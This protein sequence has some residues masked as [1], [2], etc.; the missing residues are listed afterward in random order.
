MPSYRLAGILLLAL[1]LCSVGQ[2]TQDCSDE[3]FIVSVLDPAGA[4]VKDLVADNFRVALQ[5]QPAKLA[6]VAHRENPQAR[7]VVLLD[8]SGSMKGGQSPGKWRTALAAASDFLSSAP[9]QTQITFMTFDSKVERIFAATD[10]RGPIRGFLSEP[11]VQRGAMLKGKTAL[12]DVILKALNLLTPPHPGDAIYVITDGGDNSS[13]ERRKQL[14]RA[15]G[16][17]GVRLFGF[18]LNGSSHESEEELV[19]VPELDALVR[20]AGGLVTTTSPFKSGPGWVSS[21]D[22]S[23]DSIARERLFTRA[24]QAAIADFY[25]IGIQPGQADLKHLR[26][27]VVNPEGKLRKDVTISYPRE[28]APRICGS[29]K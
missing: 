25:V 21:Y 5:G 12:Y 28:S 18:L 2:A 14:S 4:P 13:A 26:V 19:G 9:P 7:V 22:F 8:V 23:Q 20:E 29:P 27:N 15:L 16:E 11:A 3:A 1:P 24:V 17:S 10:G 6:S